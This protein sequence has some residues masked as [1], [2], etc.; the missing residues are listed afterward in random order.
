MQPNNPFNPL[1][2]FLGSLGHNIQQFVQP[3]QNTL[4]QF[5]PQSDF[6][7]D[8]GRAP[9]PPQISMPHVQPVQAAQ[10]AQMA[11][12]QP[13]Q[14]Q[15]PTAA[16]FKQGLQ[17]YDPRTPLATGSAQLAQGAAQLPPKVD[18]YLAAV[19][20]LMETHGGLYQAAQNDPFNTYGIQN[21]RS[22]FINYPDLTTAILG[23]NNNGVPAQG[24]YGNI[25]NNSAYA[26]FRQSGNLS[27]FFSAYTPWKDKQGN[28]IN[29]DPQTLIDRY[30]SLR[31]YF[32]Q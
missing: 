2:Q 23:G 16:Q 19:I 7:F 20:S 27:D 22:Q 30:N 32:P 3:V 1:G 29:P 28:I 18:P 25:M 15:A 12:Q 11:P 13:Q 9:K 24:F 31:H 4:S 5:L 14:R 26:P 17:A 6:K 21:G 8:Y 10:P